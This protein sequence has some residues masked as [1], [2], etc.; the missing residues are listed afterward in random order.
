MP[1]SSRRS[2]LRERRKQE[3]RDEIR[4]VALELVQDRGYDAV[5]VDLISERAGVSMRT[6]FNYFANKESAMIATP[7][8]LTPAAVEVFLSGSGPRDLV[9]DLADL[10]ISQLEEEGAHPSDFEATMQIV[11]GVPA[12]AK[13]QFAVFVELETQFTELIA[14]RL[15]LDPDDAQPAVIAAAFLAAVRVA[16]QR[17]SRNSVQHNLGEEVRSCLRHL[18]FM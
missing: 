12:L 6:F 2:T 9:T 14:A 1:A 15:S 11:L 4:R 17:W 18:T 7:P 16:G 13:L 5:T 3:T 8:R 10:A